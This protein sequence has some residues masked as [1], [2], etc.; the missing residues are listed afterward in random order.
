MVRV[1]RPERRIHHGDA[2]HAEVLA[3]HGLNEVRAAVLQSFSVP[4]RRALAVDRT[5]AANAT[6]LDIDSTDESRNSIFG[7]YVNQVVRF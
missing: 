4:P 3:V 1:H 6:V 2:C 5:D 7:L